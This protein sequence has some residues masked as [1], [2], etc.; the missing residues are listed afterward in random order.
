MIHF[1][2]FAASIPNRFK[3]K[4]EEAPHHHQQI[5]MALRDKK[6]CFASEAAAYTYYIKGIRKRRQKIL[7]P[8]DLVLVRNHA[9]DSQRERKLE[10]KW[11]GLWIL[12]SYFASR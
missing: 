12:V 11:P 7:K 9:V 2:V 6:K 5:F 8:G 1:D 3:A 4:I 10:T